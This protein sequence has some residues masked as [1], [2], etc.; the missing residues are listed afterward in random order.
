M[1]VLF[2]PFP[3]APISHVL[4]LLALDTLLRDTDIE[5]AFLLPR[6]GHPIVSQVADC[7]L[8][9]DHQGFRTE[10]EAYAKFAPDVVV[11]DASPT[12]IYASTMT[13]TPRIAIQRTGMFPGAIPRHAHHRHSMGLQ[14]EQLPDVTFMG[15]KQPRTFAELFEAK[16]KIVPGIPTIEVLPPALQ[17]DPS[18]VFAGPLIMPDYLVEQIGYLDNAR[19]SPNGIEFK[20]FN[21]LLEFLASTREQRKVYITFGSVAKAMSTIFDCIRYLLDLGIVVI[22]SIRVD[23]LT[24]QQRSLYY[25]AVYL[26]LHLVCANVDLAIHHCGSATYHY[27]ILHDLPAITIGTL[28]YDRDDVAMRLEE[29]GVSEHIPAP[30]ECSDFFERFRLSVDRYFDES[31][32]LRQQRLN[33]IRQ[34]KQGIATTSAV[35]DFEQVLYDAIEP[36]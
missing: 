21:P 13:R 15:L 2:V 32:N 11:D 17:N 28:C 25:H 22:T 31:T 7:V 34:I 10:M 35:F 23:E 19:R 20:S 1:R 27:P 36:E 33:S 9:I 12:T 5:T 29:L 6:G 3:T 4:P 18:Y 14:I 16:I 30:E 26:P 24:D 8:D